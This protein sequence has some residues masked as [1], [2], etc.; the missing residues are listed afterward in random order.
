MG[1]QLHELENCLKVKKNC[2]NPKEGT[3]GNWKAKRKIR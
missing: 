2:K 3:P 1:E